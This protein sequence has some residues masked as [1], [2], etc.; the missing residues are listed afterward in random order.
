[1]RENSTKRNKYLD[2]TVE[3]QEGMME[4]AALDRPSP[5]NPCGIHIAGMSPSRRTALSSN[6][7]TSRWTLPGILR[8]VRD[9]RQHRFIRGSKPALL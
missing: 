5:L 7:L 3:N 8:F 4:R 2:R 1:M 9:P 6:D